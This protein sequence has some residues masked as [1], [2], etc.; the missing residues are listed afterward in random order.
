MRILVLGSG[1]RE[2][3]IVEALSRSSHAPEI[4]C[5]PGNGGTAMLGTNV[6]VAFEDPAAPLDWIERT[7]GVDLVV[8]GPEAPLV[9]GI[10]NLMQAAGVPCFGPTADGAEIEGSKWF[11]KELMSRHG[12]PT[13]DAAAF[14][15]EDA[16]VA[17]IEEHGAP[18]VVKADGLAA[19]KGVTV[20]RTEEEARRAVHE[21]FSGTFGQA[22]DVVV[23]EDFLEGPECSLLA[24]ADG[25]TVLPMV[26][27]QDHKRAF[28]NDEGPNTGGMGVYS[29]VP[30]VDDV[31]LAEMTSIL[32]RTVDGMR[33]E[34]I[35]YR[36]VLYG[37]FI[38]T[39]GGPKVLEFNARFGDPEAQVVLPRLKTDLVDVMRATI[40]GRLDQIQ[41][42]WRDE[43]AVSVVLASGGYPGGYETGK[44]IH[45]L[46]EASG[47]P[48]VIV[49][50]AG[51][52]LQD[53][54][55]LV[56]S[57][58]RVLDVTALAPTLAQARERAYEAVARI[59]FEGIQYRTDIGLKA[60]QEA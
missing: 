50:H 59:S 20:A 45:G 8:V 16:A 60:L 28:D 42:E 26:P 49:F 6:D 4:F 44:P 43:A 18:L 58:G 53:D 37:G 14:D 40:E 48:G 36:G 24:F 34:G 2:H 9:A 5:A 12:I 17:Y 46:A 1:G 31:T 55:I 47:L 19:G 22:G 38:L 57:G 32:T 51:T 10:T 3:A 56:T 54:G 7:G 15:S 11:A 52:K 41:L 30:L 13:A 25:E 27:A 23:L 39:A 21:C 35:V 29:P 33:E